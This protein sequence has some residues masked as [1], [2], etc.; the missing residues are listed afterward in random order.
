MKIKKRLVSNEDSK[1]KPKNK[2]LEY[3]GYTLSFKDYLEKHVFS[4]RCKNYFTCKCPYLLNVPIDGNYDLQ[5]WECV[6]LAGAFQSSTNPHTKTCRDRT[7]T[8]PEP[9]V[10][11]PQNQSVDDVIEWGSDEKYLRNYLIF[12]A[13]S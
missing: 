10:E 5:T 2:L 8:K 9:K 13:R 3:Q 11:I 7:F 12:I 6:N 4:Y 1:T